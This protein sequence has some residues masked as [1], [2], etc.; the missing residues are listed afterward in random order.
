MPDILTAILCAAVLGVM[1]WGWARQ[2][3]RD[4]E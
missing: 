2:K 1:M 4:A 3:R